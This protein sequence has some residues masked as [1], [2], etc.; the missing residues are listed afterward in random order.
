MWGASERKER[1]TSVST[2]ARVVSIAGI[3]VLMLS[4]AQQLSEQLSAQPLLSPSKRLPSKWRMSS[5]DFSDAHEE[6]STERFRK[7]PAGHTLLWRQGDDLN[8][9]PLT[10]PP[11]PS[12]LIHQFSYF[13]FYYRSHII[14]CP[15]ARGISAF[16]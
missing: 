16:D 10:A 5:R 13:L 2:R 1:P 9:D 15:C 7:V 6:C 8:A 4:S 11:F 12:R 3:E 14:L